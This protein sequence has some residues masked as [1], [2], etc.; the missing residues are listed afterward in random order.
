MQIGRRDEILARA[1][2]LKKNYDGDL[3]GQI[4]NGGTST[5]YVSSVPFSRIDKALLAGKTSKKTKKQV[6]LNTPENLLEKQSLWSTLS[7]FSPFLGVLAAFGIAG[8][9]SSQ[10]EQEQ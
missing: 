7:L 5:V 4:E 10:E 9:K 8:K 3:Y 2:Q 6:R 1:D